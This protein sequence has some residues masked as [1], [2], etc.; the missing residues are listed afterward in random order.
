MTAAAGGVSD[1]VARAIGQR[2]GDAWG[3]QVIIENKGGGAHIIGEG[4]VAAAR[5][6]GHTLL[7]A[8]RST[9]V[10]NPHLYPKGKLPYDPDTAF[11]PI[12]ALVGIHHAF[13]TSPSLAANSVADVIAMAKAKP[14]QV[15][16]G[17]AGVASG[18]HVNMVRLEN[19]TSTAFVP[20][21]YRGATPSLNDVVGSHTNIMLISVSSALP[22]FRS[23]QVKMLGIGSSQRLPEVSDVPTIAEGGKLPGFTAGTWF[24]LAVTA[25]TPPAVV[26]KISDEVLKILN[27]P[28]FRERFLAKQLYEL[29]A[30]SPEA[31][32]AACRR[33]RRAPRPAAWRSPSPPT[34]PAAR[35]A[36]GRRGR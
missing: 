23:G 20:V 30:S 17:T 18:P 28:Q 4:A 27:E 34:R 2:L 16:Y 22:S 1:I 14:N 31:P 9:F 33:P 19:V 10:I 7:V 3:Q 26:K 12:T 24:G 29:L 15:T 11:I 21:H 6:D 35:P 5:P 25:G 8:E 32:R 13:I 36:G